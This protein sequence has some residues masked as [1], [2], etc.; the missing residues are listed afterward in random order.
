MVTQEQF[1]LAVEE[2]Y[3]GVTLCLSQRTYNIH[4]FP[5]LCAQHVVI[6]SLLLCFAFLVSRGMLFVVCAVYVSMAL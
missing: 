1:A 5:S 2:M 4:M 6:V 3:V